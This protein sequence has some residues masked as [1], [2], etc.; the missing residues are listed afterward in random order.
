[1]AELMSRSALEY[2]DSGQVFGKELQG[3]KSAEFGVF[4]FVNDTL[5][6]CDPS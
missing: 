5:E 3:D 6:L 2:A 4:G 1:M